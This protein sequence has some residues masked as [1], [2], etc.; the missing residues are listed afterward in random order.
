MGKEGFLGS[1]RCLVGHFLPGREELRQ[2]IRNNEKDIAKEESMTENE[3]GTGQNWLFYFIK[4]L[5]F[6]NKRNPCSL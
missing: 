5:G 3:G 4:C 6:D 2:K 1:Q